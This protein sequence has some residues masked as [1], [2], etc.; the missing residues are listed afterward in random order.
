MYILVTL[1]E[2]G[3]TRIVPIKWIQGLTGDRFAKL[4]TNGSRFH[5][6]V[7][8]KI[9]YFPNLNDEPDFNINIQQRI[10]DE[11]RTACYEAAIK[12]GFGKYL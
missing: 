1:K 3:Q 12:K 10:V 7:F 2:S 4:L 8:Y 11:S 6:R 5:K 9:F